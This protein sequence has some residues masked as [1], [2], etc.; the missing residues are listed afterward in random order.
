M[1]TTHKSHH[2]KDLKIK[3]NLKKKLIKLIHQD[4]GY[5]DFFFFLH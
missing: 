2:L 4:L 1:I 3:F 5:M